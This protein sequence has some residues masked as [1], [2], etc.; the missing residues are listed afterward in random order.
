MPFSHPSPA[1]PVAGLTFGSSSCTF[2]NARSIAF[3]ART[4]GR[5]ISSRQ[6]VHRGVSRWM[7][8]VDSVSHDRSPAIEEP[9]VHLEP[10]ASH[11]DDH[12]MVN[13]E[14]TESDDKHVDTNGNPL[15]PFDD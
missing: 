9:H 10:P 6:D 7:T 2:R 4:E 1:K 14:N 3:Y 12:P 5:W 13:Q 8:G 11:R 15:R